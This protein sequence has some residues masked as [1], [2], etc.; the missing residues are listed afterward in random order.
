ME[1]VILPIRNASPKCRKKIRYPIIFTIKSNREKIRSS[2]D[3]LLLLPVGAGI[4]CLTQS[5][6]YCITIIADNSEFV[7]LCTCC[8]ATVFKFFLK[9]FLFPCPRDHILFFFIGFIF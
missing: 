1:R 4:S 2:G 9:K 8:A 6:Y 5:L 3:V 7:K